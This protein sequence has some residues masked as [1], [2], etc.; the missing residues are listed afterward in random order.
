MLMIQIFFGVF[1][2]FLFTLCSWPVE[3]SLV[4]KTKT[5]NFDSS[6]CFFLFQKIGV[7]KTRIKLAVAERNIKD[8][9]LIN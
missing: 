1:L 3:T 4:S 6:Y 9:R 7:Y 8:V 5:G 2:S